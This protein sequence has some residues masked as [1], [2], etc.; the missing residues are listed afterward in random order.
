[1]RSSK[2]LI[3][4]VGFRNP[5]DVVNCLRALAN[6]RH[7]NFVVSICENGGHEA[8]LALL[9]ELKDISGPAACKKNVLI[10]QITETATRSLRPHQQKI[11]VLCA[12]SNLGFAGG[13]NASLRAFA[14]DENWS[15]VWLLNPDTIADP[16]ALQALIER[17]A[18]TGADIV[19]SRLVLAS[20]GKIQVYG[21]G[22]WRPLLA[23]GYNLGLGADGDAPV[24]AAEI[25][26]DLDF[27]SGASLFAS[28]EFIRKHGLMNERYFLY[29]EEIE[30]CMR[31]GKAKLAYA[32][33]AI[34][35]HFHGSTIGSAR[36][37]AARPRLAVYLDERNRLLFAQDRYRDIYPLVVIATFAMIWRYLRHGSVRNFF[38]ALHG[39]M[40]GLFGRSGR[41]TWLTQG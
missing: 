14:D 33:D 24:D 3:S 18:E 7:Q 16:G 21:G 9:R 41:P 23:R 31:S 13:V 11:H 40:D 22:R 12:A 19:G 10:P 6:S 1:M 39:W 36:K 4:I 2:I 38:V 17:R 32:H 30:W 25:E 34:V 20:T 27:V 8:Y 15:A 35:H 29:Y 5:S 26:K 37:W 28:R